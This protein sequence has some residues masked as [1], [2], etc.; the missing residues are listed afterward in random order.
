MDEGEGDGDGLDDTDITSIELDTVLTSTRR[1][2]HERGVL[3]SSYQRL[4][5]DHVDTDE[6]SDAEQD[7]FFAS[8]YH[9]ATGMERRMQR[10]ANGEATTTT[11]RS[12]TRS[13]KRTRK[14]DRDAPEAPSQDPAPPADDPPSDAPTS[15]NSLINT[16]I[17]MLDLSSIIPCDLYL[18]HHYHVTGTSASAVCVANRELCHARGRADLAQ[19][20]HMAAMVTHPEIMAAS[21]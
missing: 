13:M 16:S 11:R 6:H 4:R 5:G 7:E 17:L 9:H 15:Q 2:R 3:A 21:E 12:L 20:W 19:T 10:Q 1:P 18:A 14:G 8:F